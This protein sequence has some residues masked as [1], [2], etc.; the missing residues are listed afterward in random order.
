MAEEQV[1]LPDHLLVLVTMVVRLQEEDL[2]QVYQPDHLLV[3]AIMV[4]PIV[5]V[6]VVRQ[7]V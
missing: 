1:C 2:H 7:Q 5:A 4:Q 3:R 6:A